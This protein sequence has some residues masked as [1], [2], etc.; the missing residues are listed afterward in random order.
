M[1]PDA[2]T[3]ALRRHTART[4]IRIAA[5]LMFALGAHRVMDLVFSEAFFGLGSGRVDAG[6]LFSIYGLIAILALVAPWPLTAA[7]LLFFERRLASWLVPMPRANRC[8][9]CDYD[10]RYNTADRC[11]ECGLRLKP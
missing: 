11:P 1:G 3:V 10:L 5:V 4:F 7:A 6:Q 8:P 2:A 9:A